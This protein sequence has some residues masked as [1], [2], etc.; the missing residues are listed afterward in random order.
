MNDTRKQQIQDIVA[1]YTNRYTAACMC[2]RLDDE[3]RYCREAN[4]WM[5]AQKTANNITNEELQEAIWFL[6]KKAQEEGQA[7]GYDTIVVK[8]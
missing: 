4:T 6:E 1:I 5:L 8:Q 2:D 3:E 7:F